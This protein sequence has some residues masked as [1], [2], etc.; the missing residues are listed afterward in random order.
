M[1]C[2]NYHT[3]HVSLLFPVF[4]PLLW[5]H[6][7]CLLDWEVNPR[8]GFWFWRVRQL[9]VALEASLTLVPK[10]MLEKLPG[11]GLILNY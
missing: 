9:S 8:Q 6:I 7:S 2:I 11:G 4:H 5:P 1:Q 3:L 10:L